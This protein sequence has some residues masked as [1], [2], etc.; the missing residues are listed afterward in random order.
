[1]A[2]KRKYDLEDL[3]F[4]L[5]KDLK[6]KLNTYIKAVF[7]EKAD[8][9][10]FSEIPETAFVTQSLDTAIMN[11]KIFCFIQC[12]EIATLSNGPYAAK[13][14]KI[15]VLIV[16]SGTQNQMKMVNRMLRYGRALEDTIEKGWESIGRQPVK[17]TL[18]S[19]P[20][21]DYQNMNSTQDFRVVGVEI[22]ATIA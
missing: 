21:A 5:E 14:Y 8:G 20:P 11:N 4:D 19:I 22:N 18:T 9:L 6:A 2:I 17:F 16:V 3:L 13:T 7:A 12:S 10:T 1:M 15:I